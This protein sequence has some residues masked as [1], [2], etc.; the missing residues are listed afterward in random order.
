[1]F[2]LV[3]KL[4]KQKTIKGLVSIFILLAFFNTCFAKTQQMN[5]TAIQK[6]LAA[7]EVSSGGRMGLFAI[8]ADNNVRIQY[9]A[10]ERFPM[11]S[12]SKLIAIS[13]MLNK[14]IKDKHLLQHIITYTKADVEES[15]YAPA[16]KNHITEGMMVKDLCMAAI[17]QSDNAAMNL[18]MKNLGG[19]AAVTLFAHSMGDNAFRLDRYEPELNSAIPGDLRDTTTPQAM[20]KSLQKLA[21]GDVLAPKQQTLLL[22]W[23]KK[24]TTGHARIRAGVP[25][26]WLVGDKT[27]TGS[28]GTTNDVGIIWPPNASPI[29]IAIYFTQNKKDASPRDDV[30][31]S[32][33]RIVIHSLKNICT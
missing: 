10:Q 16:T 13:A 3:N 26:T 19:P 29:V 20:A 21:F 24:N 27:G 32:V 5:T 30:I 1:M 14:S 9:L 31:A 17:T 12:T 23:M 6:K 25:E 11:C 33:T 22:D 15:G 7:L 18:I 8:S 4:K 28:F 2:V